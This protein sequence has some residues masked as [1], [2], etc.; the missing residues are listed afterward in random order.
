MVAE[1]HGGDEWLNRVAPTN[2]EEETL[3]L[4]LYMTLYMTLKN[5][6]PISEGFYGISQRIYSLYQKLYMP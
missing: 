5:N 6:C 3:Y 1:K 4:T 2:L